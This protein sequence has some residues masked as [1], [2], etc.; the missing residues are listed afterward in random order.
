VID[1]LTLSETGSPANVI[2]RDAEDYDIIVIGAKGRDE[3]SAGGLGPEGANR[4]AMEACGYWCR[5][6]VRPGPNRPWMR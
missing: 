5:W 6:T 3:R 1:A 4:P 2:M